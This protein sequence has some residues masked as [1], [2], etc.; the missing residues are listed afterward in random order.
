MILDTTYLLPLVG[1]GVDVDLL[2]SIVEGRAPL[3]LSDVKVS[4]VS[5]F[6]LQAKAAKYD[7]P[8][9]RVIM[10]I[11]A[12]ER[13]FPV[14]P[15][16]APRIVEVSLHLRRTL[17]KDYIDAVIAATAIALEE[18]LVTEDKDIHAVAHNLEREY[19]I[20]I[21]SY[22]KLLSKS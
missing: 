12:I 3:S 1:I 5:L 17:L 11:E 7:V 22:R 21:Y 19:K 20:K 18:P 2:R 6:E 8:V 9:D 15:F 14:I 10:A 4:L 13:A 16:T